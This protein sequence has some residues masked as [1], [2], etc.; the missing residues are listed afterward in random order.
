MKWRTAALHI[1]ARRRFPGKLRNDLV[2]FVDHGCRRT[3]QRVQPALASPDAWPSA[4]PPGVPFCSNPFE[5]LRFPRLLFGNSLTQPFGSRDAIVE[6]TGAAI[7]I[8]DTYLT[9]LQ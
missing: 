5:H 8:A 4:M 6:K 9:T 7:G 3:A 2:F 1:Q